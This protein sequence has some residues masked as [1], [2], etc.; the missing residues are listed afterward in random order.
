MLILFSN[1][2]LGIQELTFSRFGLT[3]KATFRK[4][5]V[6]RSHICII[7]ITLIHQITLQMID[8][9]QTMKLEKIFYLES[10]DPENMIKINQSMYKNS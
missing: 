10:L 8:E 6:E 4:G 9:D 2:F 5:F 3:F 1:N 7:A